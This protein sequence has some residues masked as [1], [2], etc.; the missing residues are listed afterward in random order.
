M[1]MAISPTEV[2]IFDMISDQ[3][4]TFYI[5]GLVQGKILSRENLNRKPMVFTIK[6]RGFR[7]K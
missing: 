5:N 7:L 4:M 2:G 3:K 1:T 6:Y